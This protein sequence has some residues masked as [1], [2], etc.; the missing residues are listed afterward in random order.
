MDDDDPLF[1]SNSQ[2]SRRKKGKKS[3]KKAEKKE[4][5]LID[6][7]VWGKDKQLDILI[8]NLF[9]ILNYEEAYSDEFALLR[10]RAFQKIN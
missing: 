6:F 10:K 4:E 1:E 7:N 2:L 8:E 9:K 3:G 5:M